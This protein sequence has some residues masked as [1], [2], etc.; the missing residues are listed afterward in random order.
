MLSAL[1]SFGLERWGRAAGGLLIA[2]LVMQG[3]FARLH[4][5]DYADDLRFWRGAS[6]GPTASAKAH[7]NLGVMLGARGDHAGRLVHTQKAV[8]LAPHWT[9]GNLYLADVHCRMRNRAAALPLY[10][11]H[12]GDAA[13]SKSLTALSLQCIWDS[14]SFEE[15]KHSL[16]DLAAEHPNSW[17]DYFV[18]RL[19]EDGAKNGGIPPEFRSRKYNATLDEA[20]P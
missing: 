2:F 8:A 6:R 1:V 15:S 7:L 14:G 20:R 9:M 11:A 4:A 16:M 19:R 10:L 18:Y 12:L 5:S 3:G 17:L 13:K